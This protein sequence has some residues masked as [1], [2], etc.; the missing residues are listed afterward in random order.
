MSN[1]GK[2]LVGN[3]QDVVCLILG[4]W[5]IVSPWAL[6][7]TGIESAMWNAV[8]LGIVIVVMT[9]MELVEFHDWEEWTDMVIGGWLAISPWVL[10]FTGEA[11]GSSLAAGNFLIVGLVVLAL[12]AWSLIGHH[13]DAHA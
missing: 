8:I 7:F 9:L 11:G 4:L 3:W 13:G 1:F 12:A 5:L 6:G 2:K 10:G